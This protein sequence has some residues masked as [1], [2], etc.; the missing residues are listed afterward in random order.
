MSR[1]I[2]TTYGVMIENVHVFAQVVDIFHHAVSEPVSTL[3]VPL[4]S[5]RLVRLFFQ[6]RVEPVC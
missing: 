2:G 4:R 3:L 6:M 5:A 1:A